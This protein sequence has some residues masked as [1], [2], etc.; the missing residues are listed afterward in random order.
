MTI[1]DYAC[2]YTCGSCAYFKFEGAH[3]KSKC[4]HPRTSGWYYPCD[5]CKYW[6]EAPDWYRDK[7]PIDK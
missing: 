5:E 3:E 4:G 6:E 2:K 7:R 1:Y